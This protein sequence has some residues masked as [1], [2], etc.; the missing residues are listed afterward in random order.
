MARRYD[1]RCV[2]VRAAAVA[3][4]VLLFAACAGAPTPPIQAF[5]CYDLN[6]RYLADI[7]SQI[8][9]AYYG[10]DWR[11]TPKRPRPTRRL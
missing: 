1:S 8:E 4:P 7:A 11:D 6:D 3:A 2:L 10:W 9:C 5:G